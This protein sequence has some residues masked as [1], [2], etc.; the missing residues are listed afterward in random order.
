MK[1]IVLSIILLTISTL[2][3][4]TLPIL[5]KTP[6]DNRSYFAVIF[7]DGAEMRIFAASQITISSKSNSDTVLLELYNVTKIL[8]KDGNATYSFMKK[9]EIPVAKTAEVVFNGEIKRASELTSKDIS[10]IAPKIQP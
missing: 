7:R 2:G 6:P 4:C 9:L 10:W 5:I 8:V 1:K 3:H